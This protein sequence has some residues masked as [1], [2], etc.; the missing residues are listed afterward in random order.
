MKCIR[1][2]VYEKLDPFIFVISR[3]MCIINYKKFNLNFIDPE[4]RKYYSSLF[5]SC[6][7]NLKSVST[8]IKTG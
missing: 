4:N 8:I 7:T 6:I 5:S 2:N 3:Y 1:I